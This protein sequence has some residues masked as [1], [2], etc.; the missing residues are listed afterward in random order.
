MISDQLPFYIG[1][2]A[3]QHNAWPVWLNDKQPLTAYSR[4]FNCIEG[5]TTYWQL[6]SIERVKRWYQQTPAHFR[7]AMKAPKELSHNR[8]DD[9]QTLA[10]FLAVL[11]A[12]A[13]KAGTSFM[14]LPASFGPKQLPQLLQFIDHWPAE[15]PLAIEVRH[16]SWHDRSDA[17]RRLNN[18]LKENN[19]ER[20]GFDT[21]SL[22]KREAQWSQLAPER[23]E[24]LADALQRKPRVPTKLAG[25]THTPMLRALACYHE[26]DRQQDFGR[27]T[28]Q[29]QTWC[30]QG[31]Q[32]YLFFHTPDLQDAPQLCEAFLA[33][34]STELNW[35]A[36]P[37]QPSLGW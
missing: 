3:W 30:Q 1:L 19:I 21:R 7:F 11:D 26:S 17:E 34:A 13:D 15:K 5:N 22:F 27:W 23:S 10:A 12:L 37:S 31:K 20:V 14:Q 2:P 35:P 8:L 18:L 6:P 16:P 36:V 25:F 9:A 29:L 32:P 24:G 28:N 4:Y 33:E